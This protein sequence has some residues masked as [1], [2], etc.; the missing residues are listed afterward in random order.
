MP[1]AIDLNESMGSKPH[2][3]LKSAKLLL[4]LSINFGENCFQSAL[5]CS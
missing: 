4:I 3:A 5:C 1:I 2:S